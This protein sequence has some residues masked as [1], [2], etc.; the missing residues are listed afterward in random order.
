MSDTK[1][2]QEVL[3]V[4][5]PAFFD[6]SVLNYPRDARSS[7]I[8]AA[9]DGAIQQALH[10]TH[11]RDIVFTHERVAGKVSSVLWCVNSFLKT[12]EDR[13]V[14]LVDSE[15]SEEREELVEKLGED[16]R[17][18]IY[19]FTLSC[20]LVPACKQ[21]VG[22]GDAPKPC[23]P[24]AGARDLPPLLHEGPS[25][26]SVLLPPKKISSGA[27]V[28]NGVDLPSAPASS[29]STK[30]TRKMEKALN[31]THLPSTGVLEL[32]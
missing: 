9:L 2:P 29:V 22:Y 3:T 8:R 4:L 31:S 23:V 32:D 11:R 27:T 21:A 25:S 28:S 24:G 12:P 10:L 17:V 1:S 30:E 20:S 16:S 19:S 13:M 15:M 18:A 14:V 26:E 6:E 7:S 5:S